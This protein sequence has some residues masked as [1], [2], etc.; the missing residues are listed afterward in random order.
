M[1]VREESEQR[2]ACLT[3]KRKK[4]IDYYYV[5]QSGRVD[6]KPRVTFQ[7]Y[8]GRVEDVVARLIE[9]TPLRE[10]DE[11]ACTYFGGPAALLAMADSLDLRKMIDEVVPKREQGPSVGDYILLAAI[12][13]VLAPTSKNQIGEWYETTVLKRLWGFKAEAFSSQN[14]WHHM[15]EIGE[16][17]IVAIESALVKQ[18][19]NQFKLDWSGL[20]YDTTNF[21]TFIDTTNNR[22]SLAQR[23]H[24]KAKRHDLRQVGLAMVVTRGSQIPLFHQVYQGNI[25]DST[26][27]RTTCTALADRYKSLKRDEL[28]SE[29]TVVFDKGN[30]S[31][32][33]LLLADLNEVKFV[34]S[35]KP[36]HHADLLKVSLSEYEELKD[37][38][39]PGTRAYR[40]RVDALGNERT[41]VITFSETFYSQQLSGWVH[42][43]AKAVQK[44]N[45][46]SLDISKDNSHRSKESINVSVNEILH[47]QPMRDS[48]K[49]EIIDD[50][51]NYSLFYRTD[52]QAFNDYVSKHGGKT[53]IATGNHDWTTPDII[54]AYHAQSE[55]EE[56]FRMMNGNDFLDW[57]P[58]FHW[59][60]SKIRVHGLYCVLG[61]LL[62]A[63]LRQRLSDGGLPLCFNTILDELSSMQEVE[64]SYHTGKQG[65]P[66]TRTLYN[67]LTP[68][69]KKISEM[70]NLSRFKHGAN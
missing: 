46:L 67:R 42:Q 52:Q 40:T 56:V 20:L 44:L 59:T 39:W 38:R 18:L 65:K 7:K 19:M 17:Q 31:E 2:M 9:D 53:I 4:G 16:D 58:M 69:Q 64:L 15:D 57:Q 63:V 3:K 33:N 51:K 41:A 54:A 43:M 24:S 6:G 48:I 1:P 47:K 26:Q 32:E 37:S 13:R 5:V 14:F 22:C 34:C 61:F 55:I 66:A 35:L 28:K 49:F 27:F 25:N 23:G 30:N 62:L 29:L 12:N 68:A 36:S 60:D 8:L 50:D 45:A 11:A 21:F 10:P 70:L